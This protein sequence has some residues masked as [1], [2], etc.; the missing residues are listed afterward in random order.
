MPSTKRGTTTA[1]L[2]GVRGKASNNVR[3]RGSTRGRKSSQSNLYAPERRDPIDT[4][5]PVVE[6][7]ANQIYMLQKKETLST[8]LLL[9]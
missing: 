6:K 3:G 1:A 9:T 2:R 7:A 8:P 4:G 5:P